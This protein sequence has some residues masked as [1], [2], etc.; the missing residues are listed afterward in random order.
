MILHPL[1]PIHPFQHT[2]LDGGFHSADG[3]VLAVYDLKG[4][5][6]DGDAQRFGLGEHQV[7]KDRVPV[8]ERGLILIEAG[9]VELDVEPQ[10]LDVAQGGTQGFEVLAAGAEGAV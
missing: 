2:G 8:V 3:E 5:T 1:I 9:V 7:H 10:V 6:G 4:E